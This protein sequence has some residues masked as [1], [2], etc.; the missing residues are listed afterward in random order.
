MLLGGISAFG[1]VLGAGLA[2]LSGQYP[3]QQRKMELI[4]GWLL[5]ASLGLLGAEIA[6][7]V[8]PPVR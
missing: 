2:Y 7:I 4:A 1:V 5:I 6:N 3:S 8:G